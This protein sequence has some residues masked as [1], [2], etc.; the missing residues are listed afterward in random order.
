MG[1]AARQGREDGGGTADGV[2]QSIR[3]LRG[4]AALLVVGFHAAEKAGLSFKVGAIGVDLFFVI[5]GFIIWVVTAQRPATPGTFLLNRAIRVVPLYW[6]ITLLVAGLA[7]LVPSL[8]ASRVLDPAR[9]LASLL[10]IPHLDAAGMP[11]PLLAPGWTL[12]HEAFFYLVFA[13]G[14]LLPRP[15]R[16][17][18]LTAGPPTPRRCCWNSSAGSGSA[19]PGWRVGCRDVAWASSCSPA[20]SRCPRC[21][22]RG[23][24]MRMAGARSLGAARRCCWWPGRCAWKP[25]VPCRAAIRWAGSA[26]PPT[27]CT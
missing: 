18:A 6:T 16:A 14:L 27:R 3:T 25:P 22:P 26:I 17:L 9:L 19:V 20:A 23:A 8:L 2:L 15:A 21:W 1:G 4:L 7:L 13:A 10:F 11:W 24:M 12:N 5:S